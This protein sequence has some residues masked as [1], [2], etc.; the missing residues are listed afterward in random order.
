MA[1]EKSQD[2]DWV[3]Y[4]LRRLKEE[5]RTYD[6][7]SVLRPTNPFRLPGT[8]RRAWKV[9]LESGGADSLRAVEKCRQ[10]PG[11]MWVRDGNRIR[12]L[13]TGTHEGQP[14][15]STP[16]QALPEV[17]VQNASLEIAWCR[18]VFEQKSI[19]G[20]RI[21]P[22]FTEG[23]EGFDIN[24]EMDWLMAERL[25]EKGAPLPGIPEACRA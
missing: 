15:H 9:F 10:H 4:T 14:W 18:V 24:D 17:F 21:V 6:C 5:G 25:L 8:I 20:E 12:P 13:W 7:F 16:Y 2:I 23:T 3:D 22:F 19:S 11:K 1:N